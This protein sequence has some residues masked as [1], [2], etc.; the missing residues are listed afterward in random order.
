MTLLDSAVGEAIA[1]RPG[2]TPTG[3]SRRGTPTVEKNA[4]NGDIVLALLN[5]A[6]RFFIN[7]FDAII[8]RN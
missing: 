8:L 3:G 7:F 2:T 5:G 4:K 6:S 1:S